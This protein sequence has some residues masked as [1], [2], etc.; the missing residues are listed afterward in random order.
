MRVEHLLIVW[1]CLSC[2]LAG[3]PGATGL[4]LGRIEVRGTTR[5]RPSVVLKMAGIR[6]GDPWNDEQKAL[7]LRRLNHGRAFAEVELEERVLGDRVDLVLKVQ[8]KWSL[9]PLPLFASGENRSVG[10]GLVESNFLGRQQVLVGTLVRKH[11]AWN[12]LLL[13]VE[14]HLLTR[15]YQLVLSRGR[16][17]ERAGERIG[18]RRFANVLLGR[19][20]GDYVMLSLAWH[21]ADWRYDEAQSG[22]PL[23]PSGISH[24]WGLTLEWDRRVVEEDFVRGFYL[25]ALV[26]RDL[27]FSDFSATRMVVNGDLS[28]NLLGHHTLAFA[29]VLALSRGVPAG[30]EYLLGGLGGEFTL[31][32]KGYEDRSLVSPQ[33]LGHAVEYRI[34]FWR[35]RQF[36]LS[37]VGF[38]DGALTWGAPRDPGTR[39]HGSAG[40]SLRVYL[41]RVAVPAMQFYYAYNFDEKRFRFGVQVGLGNGR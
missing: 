22:V 8:D 15:R 30:Q 17:R 27:P 2:L 14:P 12:T 1:I 5:T 6:E 21:G 10:G 20:L 36:F 24:A 19:R 35:K 31:P 28:L 18:E 29:Q 37:L 32:L 7:C 38:V 3:D 39:W 11:E 40:V 4:H 34:P 13:F 23:A 26:K 41:R 9:I 33:V 16:E 25:R